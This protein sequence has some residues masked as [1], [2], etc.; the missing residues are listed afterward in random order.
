MMNRRRLP[1]GAK[2]ILQALRPV[3]TTVDGGLSRDHATLV[4]E[5]EGFTA[6]EIP[7][8]LDLLLDRGY[9]YEVEGALR[10]TDP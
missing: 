2:D 3:L 5:N 1:P 10:L 6:D 9:L 8:Y 7:Y 4:L